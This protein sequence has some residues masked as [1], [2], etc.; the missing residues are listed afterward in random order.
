V[1][2]NIL[3]TIYK[4]L[5]QHEKSWFFV[6]DSDNFINLY[7]CSWRKAYVNCSSEEKKMKWFYYLGFL[8]SIS[9]LPGNIR[10]LNKKPSYYKNKMK[11]EVNFFL[12]KNKYCV[13][14]GVC[15]CV[16][17]CACV[18]VCMCVYKSVPWYTCG[19]HREIYQGQFSPSTLLRKNIY[20]WK[21]MF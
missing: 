10:I 16:C 3:W 8:N 9:G 2:I 21:I 20:L 18:R 1:S 19:G 5:K 6:I 14:F 17:V 4:T 15:V 7:I 11:L 12:F 13:T